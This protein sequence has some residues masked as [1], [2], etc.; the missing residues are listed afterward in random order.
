MWRERERDISFKELTYV[1]TGKCVIYE[2][3]QQAG[4]SGELTL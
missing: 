1:E 4:N 2:A 3:G